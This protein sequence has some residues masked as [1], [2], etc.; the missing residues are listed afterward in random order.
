MVT[1]H[2]FT[3]SHLTPKRGLILSL[4]AG[5]EWAD[6]ALCLSLLAGSIGWLLDRKTGTG[7]LAWSSVLDE[8]EMC[9]WKIELFESEWKKEK[10]RKQNKHYGRASDPK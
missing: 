6:S 2:Y 5:V 1:S 10:T 4:E 7:R 8:I 9:T 3:L